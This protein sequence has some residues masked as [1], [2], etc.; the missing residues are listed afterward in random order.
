VKALI[1]SPRTTQK[2]NQK[3]NNPIKNKNGQIAQSSKEIQ[4]MNQ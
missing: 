4:M 1:S 3:K 2:N